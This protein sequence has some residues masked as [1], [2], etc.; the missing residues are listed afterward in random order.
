MHLVVLGSLGFNGTKGANSDVEGEK[1]V[2]ERLQNFR[3]KM[4]TCGGRGN[5]SFFACIDRL[6]ALAIAELVF[7]IHVMWQGE[8]AMFVEVDFAVPFDQAVA[9]FKDLNHGTDGVSDLHGGTNSHFFPGFDQTAPK[10]GRGAIEAEDF[11]FTIDGK[12][13]RG[14]DFGVV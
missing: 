12:K 9:I 2:R 8:V 11:T 3:R 14:N 13:S 5:R 6:V 7:A 10:C 1:G 4:Q